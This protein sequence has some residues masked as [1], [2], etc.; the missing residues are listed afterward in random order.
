MKWG[1]GEQAA[2]DRMATLSREELESMGVDL[3]MA[4]RWAGFYR[5]EMRR[6]PENG[7]A[8][9]RAVLMAHAAE[10]LRG[11]GE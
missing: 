9:G 8:R 4:E 7:S 1:T 2:L 10:L 6:N 11:R 5:N 3:T